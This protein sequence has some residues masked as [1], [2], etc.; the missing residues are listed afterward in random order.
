MGPLTCPFNVGAQSSQAMARAHPAHARAALALLVAAL[1]L[2]LAAPAAASAG[3]VVYAFK[4]G[5][6]GAGTGSGTAT[7]SSSAHTLTLA[8]T[9]SGLTGGPI[10]AHIHAPTSAPFTGTGEVAL[11]PPS[12]P[13]FPN[14]VSGTY[15]TVIDLT[16]TAV[17]GTAYLAAAGGTA[18]AGEST[19]LS[20]FATGKAYLNIHTAANPSGEIRGFICAAGETATGPTT[21][22]REW[23]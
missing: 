5:G 22:T 12:L 21:C 8:V 4:L 13:G 11:S 3:P 1:A 16:Q 7:Y 23:C 9:Y 15:S 20:A 10:A 6:I 14:T 19:L 18:A 17:Y 2:A